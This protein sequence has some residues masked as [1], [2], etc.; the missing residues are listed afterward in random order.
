MATTPEYGEELMVEERDQEQQEAGESS[1]SSLPA[2]EDLRDAEAVELE[3][4]EA[5][6]R[7]PA[8][9]D[10]EAHRP[11]ALCARCGAVI[12]PHDDARMTVDGGWVHEACP[13]ARPS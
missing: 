8:F 1:L 5:E 7:Q 10:H 2:Y 9:E 4:A 11:G 12:Q 6:T 3:E 13:P